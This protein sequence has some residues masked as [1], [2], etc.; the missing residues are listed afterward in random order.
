MVNTDHSVAEKIV[1]VKE[2][3]HPNKINTVTTSNMRPEAQ[4][5]TLKNSRILSLKIGFCH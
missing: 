2:K 4:N 3:Q 5:T 1:P